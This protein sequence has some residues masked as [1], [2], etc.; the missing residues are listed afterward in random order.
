L[1]TAANRL[2]YDGTPCDAIDHAGDDA[3]S[4]IGGEVAT[5]SLPP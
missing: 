4:L 1:S 2:I 3:K 5:P